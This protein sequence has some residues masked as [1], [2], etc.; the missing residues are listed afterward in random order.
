MIT[1]HAYV[2]RELLKTFGLTLTALTVLFT[3]G[4]GLY[5]VVRFEGVQ[6]GDVIGLLPLLVPIVV[7][8]TMPIAALFAVTMVYGRLAADNELLACRA[9]GINIHRMFLST[10]LLSIFVAAFTLLMGSFVIPEFAQRMDDFA[11]RN[12]RD[13]IA[14]QLQGKG[15]IHRGRTGEDRL[16]FTAEKVQ[17]VTEAA[18]REKNFEIAPGLHYLLVNHP[19]FLRVDRSG[20]LVD[21]VVAQH[22]LCVFDTRVTPI[23][24]T[25]HVRNG[26]EY[27]VG[28]RAVT[29]HQQQ[30]GPIRAPLPALFRLSSMYLATL[31]RWHRAPW[32]VPRLAEDIQRFKLDLTRQRFYAR[33]DEQLRA[34]QTLE[35]VDEY[36]QKYAL[37]AKSTEAGREGLILKQGRVAIRSADGKPRTD[38]EAERIDLLTVP[39]GTKL[40]ATIRLLKT[41]RQDVLEYDRRPGV[42][43]GARHKETFNLDQVLVPDEVWQEA[44]GYSPA[45]IIN[46]TADLPI[47]EDLGDRRIGL[48]KAAQQQ[49]RKIAAE[50]NFRLG[51]TTSALVTLLMGAVL[52]VMFRGSR[53]LAAFGLALIPLFSVGFMLVLGRQLTED[54]HTTQIGPL[55][56]WTGLLLVLLADGVMLRLGVRR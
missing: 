46:P 32:E 56:T 2:L 52:G 48:Q 5:N 13:L 38:Y 39:V 31:L 3:M 23:E 30:I 19:T 22:A 55:V 8:L 12:L 24:I 33:C 7:T 50:I 40:L 26:Q 14:Q 45:M 21:F 49:V 11:R 37:T 16:T 42:G 47:G 35:L 20:D 15:F 51:Y 28:K 53:A 25:F 18:L 44:E 4:G 27:Q 36:G 9:A 54:S 1:L 43:S 29:I 17:G 10:V 6:A 41:P 34:G